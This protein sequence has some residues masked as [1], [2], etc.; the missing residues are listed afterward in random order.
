MTDSSIPQ[1]VALAQIATPLGACLAF[2]VGP[3]DRRLVDEM[4][5]R[6]IDH[7]PILDTKG[8]CIGLVAVDHARDLDPTAFCRALDGTS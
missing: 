6:H 5:T 1:K 7:A 3:V 8:R 4:I 2:R